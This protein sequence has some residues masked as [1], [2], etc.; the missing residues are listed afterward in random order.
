MSEVK[1][2]RTRSNANA[3]RNAK[4]TLYGAILNE[5]FNGFKKGN[6]SLEELIEAATEFD[7]QV[8][9]D[10]ISPQLESVNQ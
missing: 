2:K 5:T 4:K 8:N 9:G 10:S 1:A 7:A 3:I 6:H